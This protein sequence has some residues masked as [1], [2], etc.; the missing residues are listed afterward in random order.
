M[1]GNFNNGTNP[2][3]AGTNQI[4]NDPALL[5]YVEGAMNNPNFNN[6]LGLAIMGIAD[7]NPGADQVTLQMNGNLLEITAGPPA[8]GATNTVTLG[9]NRAEVTLPGLDG[10]AQIRNVITGLDQELLQFMDDFRDNDQP[11]ETAIAENEAMFRY[12]MS[13]HPRPRPGGRHQRQMRSDFVAFNL[14]YD[15]NRRFADH[16]QNAA[17]GDGNI[18]NQNTL[19]LANLLRTLLNLDAGRLNDLIRQVSGGTLPLGNNN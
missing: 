12:L 11:S 15:F 6:S 10:F 9:I 3:E 5:A 1:C 7:R 14:E 16:V 4:R 13:E 2:N 18:P 8:A 19:T 17:L